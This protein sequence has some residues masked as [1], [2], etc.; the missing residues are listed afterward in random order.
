MRATPATGDVLLGRYQLGQLVGLGGTARV[1]RAWD[2]DGGGT[3]AVKVFPPGSA[4]ATLALVRRGSRVP[5]RPQPVVQLS[6]EDRQQ[7]AQQR[8]TEN[9]GT[10]SGSTTRRGT[11]PSISVFIDRS[12]E[13][14][15][16]RRFGRRYR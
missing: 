3:V 12:T 11:S 16:P 8:P 4:A 13:D 6:P 15:R 5:P 9:A 14:R 7:R 10:L 2:H 1:F